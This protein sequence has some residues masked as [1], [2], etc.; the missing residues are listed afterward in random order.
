MKRIIQVVCLVLLSVW[1]VSC[2]GDKPATDNK[3]TVAPKTRAV[4]TSS[5]A[6]G[7]PANPV[8]EGLKKSNTFK[9]ITPK[10]AQQ[11]ISRRKNLLVVDVRSPQELSDGYIEGSSLVPFW[12]IAKGKKSLPNDRP[13]LLV[14]AVGGRSY[15]VG[16]YLNKKGYPEVYNLQGGISAWKKAGLPLQYK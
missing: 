4:E 6:Q 11:I 3:K 13:L 14:C 7:L 1:I 16:Q 10:D 5:P 15:A 2:S 9:S 8:P 12:E